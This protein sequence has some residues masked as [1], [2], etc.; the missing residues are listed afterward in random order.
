MAQLLMT[1][2]RWKIQYTFPVHFK[3]FIFGN[4]V[5]FIL[6]DTTDF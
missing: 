3:D 2:I 4:L 5:T 6:E 1:Y